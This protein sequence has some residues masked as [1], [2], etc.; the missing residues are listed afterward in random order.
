MFRRV[1]RRGPCYEPKSLIEVSSEHTPINLPSRTGGVDTNLDDLATTVEASELPDTKD[2]GRLTSSLF[3]QKREVLSLSVSLVLTHIEGWRNPGE[4]L[5]SSQA[6]GNRCRMVRD[7][8]SAQ[9]SQMERE[10]ILSEQRDIHDFLERKADHAFQEE[11][12][13]KTRF[14][15]RR[16]SSTEETGECKMLILLFVK[17]A[18]GSNPRGWNS[19]GRIN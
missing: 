11:C 6:S 4:L 13:T 8:E 3:S 10:R 18:C 2:V 5:S 16:L 17:L 9:K 7:L 14:L 1:P 19:I 12:A 15:K